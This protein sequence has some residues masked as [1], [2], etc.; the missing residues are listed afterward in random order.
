[1]S[2]RT[3]QQDAYALAEKLLEEPN[4]DPDDTGQML[5]QMLARQLLRHREVIERM[6]KDIREM[7]D[8]TADL[9]QANRDAILEKHEEAV[10][11]IRTCLAVA[12]VDKSG[13]RY[14]TEDQ[15]KKI[16]A[17]LNALSLFHPMHCESWKGWPE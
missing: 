4:T 11:R 13:M 17:I 6:Q 16:T 5:A 8:P 14:T 15:C 9:I 12:A 3:E 2:K 7:Y 10:R 1:M